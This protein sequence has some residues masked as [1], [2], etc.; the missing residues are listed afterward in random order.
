M[1][2]VHAT[3]ESEEGRLPSTAE[4]AAM[5]AFNEELAKAGVILDGD[6]LQ[7]SAKGARVLFSGSKATVVD[8][9]FA[10]TKDLISGYWI[11][12]LPSREKAIEW[13]KRAPF[14]EGNIIEI[15]PFFEPE[16]F[17]R[18]LTPELKAKEEALRGRLRTRR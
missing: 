15:R 9:P 1:I 6:G 13:V 7:P 12:N 14:A 17:G 10:E 2:L 4:L 18:N 3:K 16:D 5:G 8:G 11:W